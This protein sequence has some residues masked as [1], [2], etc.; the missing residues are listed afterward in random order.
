[1][2][3]LKTSDLFAFARCIKSIGLKEEIKKIAMEA[4]T[5]QDI[6]S[7]GFDYFYIL[8][9]KAVEKQSEKAIY[10][11]LSGPFEMDPEAIENMDPVDWLEDLS[12]IADL[13]KWKAFFRSAAPLMQ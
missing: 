10:E 11:F 8:F 5:V 1:M 4:N 2:R 3:N 7:R 12:K 6:A 13:D 9:E